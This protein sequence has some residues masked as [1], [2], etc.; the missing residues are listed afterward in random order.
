MAADDSLLASFLS[1]PSATFQDYLTPIFP[2][3]HEY[4]VDGYNSASISALVADS[5]QQDTFSCTSRNTVR[6]RHS[7]AD[8]DIDEFMGRFGH[9]SPELRTILLEAVT[10]H[11][12][13]MNALKGL[14]QPNELE[15]VR[16]IRRRVQNRN[17]KRKSRERKQ[18]SSHPSEDIKKVKTE[19]DSLPDERGSS[20][21]PRLFSM[22][23]ALSERMKKVED[24][25]KLLSQP[26]MFLATADNV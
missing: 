14:L 26:D 7:N 15:E 20:S 9:F 13:K 12:A 22:V 17:S 16:K 5:R 1:N 25:L 10:A 11:N 8:A 23:Q 6:T 3:D 18:E 4:P 24:E 2:H 21:L 19:V